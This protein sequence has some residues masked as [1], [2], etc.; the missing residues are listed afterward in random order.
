MQICYILKLLNIFARIGHQK[1]GFQALAVDF[2]F[3]GVLIQI[4]KK[5]VTE[6]ILRMNRG[7][8]TTFLEMFM[9]LLVASTL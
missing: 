2:H 8:I 3:C 6:K 9:T 4:H 5:L 7:L 1:S